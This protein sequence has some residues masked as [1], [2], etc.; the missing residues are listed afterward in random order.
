M[1]PHA[2]GCSG[3]LVRRQWRGID[4]P[5]RAGML[6]RIT[7][8]PFS[9]TDVPAR[10]GMLRHRQGGACRCHRHPRTRGDAPQDAHPSR[11]RAVMSP[12]A[13]GCSVRAG[14]D[15]LLYRRCPRT[16]GDAP[17]PRVGAPDLALMSPHARGC[18][19]VV[20]PPGEFVRDVPT[21]AGMLRWRGRRR[22]AFGGCPRTRGDAPPRRDQR[23]HGAGDVPAR[24]GMLRTPWTP[25]RHGSRRPRTR[26]DPPRPPRDG[27]YLGQ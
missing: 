7:S 3:R 20:V 9:S 1:S 25:P 13:R 4:V 26:G 14:Q 8:V 18:S 19:G 23:Q 16:R 15:G 2:R 24:A 11:T 27:P 6:R 5:A 10:A 21:R 22:R 17:R 12:H